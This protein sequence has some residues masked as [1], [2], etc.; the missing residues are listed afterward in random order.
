VQV[1]HRH[2]VQA[3]DRLDG[4]A[5]IGQVREAVCEYA[6]GEIVT[7]SPRRDVDQLGDRQGDDR[8]REVL[9]AAAGVA[10]VANSV[11]TTSRGPLSVATATAVRP[12]R[13]SACEPSAAR[14]TVTTTIS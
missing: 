12:R 3:G 5:G 14:G 1:A 7:R 2:G 8:V 10:S 6:V 4:E 11:A 9:L 13:V